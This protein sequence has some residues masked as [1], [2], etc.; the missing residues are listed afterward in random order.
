MEEDSNGLVS[1]PTYRGKSVEDFA[2]WRFLK[3]TYLV[4]IA[5]SIIW[6]MLTGNIATETYNRYKLENENLSKIVKSGQYQDL[7][8]SYLSE[9][10]KN[11]TSYSYYFDNFQT[12]VEQRTGLNLPYELKYNDVNN[13][14]GLFALSIVPFVFIEILRSSVVYII[15]IKGSHGVTY[16]VSKFLRLF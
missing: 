8:N 1:R 12:F 7:Y 15:G 14:S 10:S 6:M 2:W 9:R 4:L 16:R 13:A 11:Q 3:L 5:T